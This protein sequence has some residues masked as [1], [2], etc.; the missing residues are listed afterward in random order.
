M[1]VLVYGNEK[2]ILVE[3]IHFFGPRFDSR[4]TLFRCGELRIV[5]NRMLPAAHFLRT[6]GESL[7]EETAEHVTPGTLFRFRFRTENVSQVKVDD[8]IVQQPV[9]VKAGVVFSCH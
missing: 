2:E 5:F 4:V 3:N 9:V 6:S 8:G 7:V 1:R